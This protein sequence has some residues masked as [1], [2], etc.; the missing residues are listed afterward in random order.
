MKKIASIDIGT[1]TIRLLVAEIH[2]SGSLSALYRDRFIVRLG[3]GMN[4]KKHLSNAAINRAVKCI[5]SFVNKSKELGVDKIFAA[6][7]ACVREAGNSRLFLKLVFDKTGI[8]PSVLSGH[9]EAILTLKGVQSVYNSTTDTALVMDIGGGSTELT[10][11]KNRSVSMVESLPLGVM[12]LTEKY[13]KHDPPLAQEVEALI[14]N[15]RFIIKSQSGLLSSIKN[16]FKLSP[17]FIGTAGTMTTLAAMDQEM[18]SYDP[19]KINRHRLTQKKIQC[20]LKEMLSKNARQRSL[21]PGLEEARATVIIPGTQI[22]LSVMEMINC[23]EIFVSDAGLP[24][25]IILD[26]LCHET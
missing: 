15:V 4:K 22:V 16:D 14:R 18:T 13:L 5:A 20:L 10:L 3:E 23:S 7:T 26:K 25:G 8:L 9:E 21:M 12:G 24:E 1:Q 2:T 19:C 17:V 6:A 11:I